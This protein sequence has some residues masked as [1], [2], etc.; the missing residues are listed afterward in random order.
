MAT[1][2]KVTLQDI[3]IR[4]EISAP[5]ENRY[6]HDYLV[7]PNATRKINAS[8]RK[9]ND[10]AQHCAANLG[11]K[12]KGRPGVALHELLFKLA[13]LGSTG[14][15]SVHPETEGDLKSSALLGVRRRNDR[16]LQT[17]SRK[18]KSLTQFFFN[19]Y[20]KKAFFR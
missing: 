5:N 15:D 20:E 10:F 17:L 4:V 12:T 6:W 14:I 9:V 18:D 1:K 11:R 7:F 2:K 13:T 8:A 16:W 19:S 3:A